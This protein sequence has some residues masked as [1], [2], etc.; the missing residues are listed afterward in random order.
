MERLRRVVY[1]LSLVVLVSS[2][3]DLFIN[4]LLFLRGPDVLGHLSVFSPFLL[5]LVGR[6]SL[7]VGLLTIFLLLAG[8]AVL[9]LHEER[10]GSRVCGFLL[11]VIMACAAVLHAPLGEAQSWAISVF[12][13]L[14]VGGTVSLFALLRIKKTSPRGRFA[15]TLL[16]TCL[17]MSFIFAL[18]YQLYLLLGAA[19]LVT[20]PLSLGAYYAAVYSIMA[21]TLAAFSY[22]LLVPSPGFRLGYRDFGKAAALPTLI[23]APALYATMQSFFVTQILAMVIAMSTNFVLAHDMLRVLLALWW[24]F[25][26]AIFI[27]LLKGRGSS[28]KFLLG[29][30]IGLLL[31]MNTTM[32][33]NY[34]YYLMLGTTGMLLLCQPH[35]LTGNLQTND[36]F[37]E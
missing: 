24:F 4:R 5:G 14:I 10:F 13:L 17:V 1:F 2:L 20:L 3:V 18:Y 11:I 22:A 26:T 12:V 35:V 30:A 34:P 25:L 33:F 15:P 29:E 9:L 7:T 6:I 23:V 21:S 19:G 8:A 27:I 31:I 36:N 28:S 32:L 37:S 16:L